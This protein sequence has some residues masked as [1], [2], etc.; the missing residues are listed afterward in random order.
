VYYLYAFRVPGSAAKFAEALTAEGAPASQYAEPLYRLPVF[1]GWRSSNP[2]LHVS[3]QLYPVT[4][5]C[6]RSTVVI[7]HV[8]AGMTDE[9]IDDVAQAIEKVWQHREEL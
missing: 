5:E 4:E 2:E 7:P 3:W 6:Y 8:H 9:D 1:A